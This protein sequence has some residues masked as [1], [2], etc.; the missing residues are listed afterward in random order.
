LT[1]GVQPSISAN[2]ISHKSDIQTADVKPGQAFDWSL[3]LQ[4]NFNPANQASTMISQQ[5]LQLLQQQQ[6]Q[7]QQQVRL[8]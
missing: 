4:S 5:I 7:Q 1:P 6:H 8:H 2:G 3:G